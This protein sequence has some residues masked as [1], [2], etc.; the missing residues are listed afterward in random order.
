MAKRWAT[1]PTDQKR[2]VLRRDA[3]L[4]TV[5]FVDPAD[6]LPHPERETPMP[7]KPR[8]IAAC[9]RTALTY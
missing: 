9:G 4:I 6:R 5:E 8:S 7:D 1:L 2:R 3:P